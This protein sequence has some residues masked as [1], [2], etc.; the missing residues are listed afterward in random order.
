MIGARL[1]TMDRARRTIVVSSEASRVAEAGEGCAPLRDL[2]QG[3]AR[4]AYSYERMP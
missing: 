2:P 4:H 1:V 3:E